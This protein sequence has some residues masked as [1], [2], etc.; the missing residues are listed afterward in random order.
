MTRLLDR[1][2]AKYALAEHG[3]TAEAVSVIGCGSH[4]S[5]V[6]RALEK[7]V[8]LAGGVVGMTTFRSKSHPKGK[9][10]LRGVRVHDYMRINHSFCI[11]GSCDVAEV[12]YCFVVKDSQ[13]EKCMGIK[14]CSLLPFGSL[15]GKLEE[16]FVLR[17]TANSC[18]KRP[19]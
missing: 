11:V 8:V 13:D 5:I 12:G 3:M 18:T 2:D 10:S 9:E 19:M 6:C 15:E 16:C 4:A 14:G 7:G 1:R 17:S